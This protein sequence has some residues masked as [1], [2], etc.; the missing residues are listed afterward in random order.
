M[1]NQDTRNNNQT[2]TNNQI[3]ITKQLISGF[4][5]WLLELGYCLPRT[6]CHSIKRARHEVYLVSWSLVIRK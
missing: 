6:E 3:S 5:D 2:M 1:N 4:G